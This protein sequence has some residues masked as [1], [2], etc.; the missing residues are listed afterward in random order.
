ML[1]SRKKTL[2]R[3]EVRSFRIISFIHNISN[4]AVSLGAQSRFISPLSLNTRI[5]AS[6]W[7]ACLSGNRLCVA[8]TEWWK[9]VSPAADSDGVRSFEK[10]RILE[11]NQT[12]ALIWR[13]NF[14]LIIG[15]YVNKSRIGPNCKDACCNLRLKVQ[16]IGD[17]VTRWNSVVGF[18]LRPFYFLLYTRYSICDCIRAVLQ[19]DW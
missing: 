4:I 6:T 15:I 2:L 17:V 19:T 5:G 12:F 10:Q 18:M 11:V 8:F 3:N 13:T 9:C 14:V 7:I 16:C 1:I